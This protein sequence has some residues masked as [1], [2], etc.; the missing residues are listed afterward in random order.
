[1]YD[2]VKYR[3]YVQRLAEVGLEGCFI[4]D[5]YRYLDNAF[6]PRLSCCVYGNRRFCVLCAELFD[7]LLLPGGGD[8]HPAHFNGED[9][10]CGG[11]DSG[12]DRMQFYLAEAF[13]GRKKPVLGI[14]KGMQLLNVL[15][16]GDLKVHLPE[17][18]LKRHDYDRG[19][20]K[21]RMHLSFLLMER[22][23]E[24]VRCM[25]NSAHHQAV[26]R[27]G[28]NL[29]VMQW[30]EDGVMEGICHENLPVIGFQWHPERIADDFGRGIWKMA[31][32]R[33]FLGG[34][35]SLE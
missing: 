26:N 9:K 27:I 13:M 7:G 22:N 30:S 23:K 6:H 24:P 10:G 5:A 29:E 15:C 18:V 16:G 32:E 35:F 11:I 19:Q 33:L 14:C 17:E 21:D 25:V 2:R 8:L 34:W 12:L 28:H 3:R 31:W 1:M 20:E 4:Q